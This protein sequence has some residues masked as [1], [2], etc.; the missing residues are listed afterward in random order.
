MSTVEELR[1]LVIAK[2][3]EIKALKSQTP[4]PSNE[5]I[6]PLVE[7]L[8]ALKERLPLCDFF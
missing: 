7:E 5:T 4:K 8:K 6:T 2:G 3:D 1:A